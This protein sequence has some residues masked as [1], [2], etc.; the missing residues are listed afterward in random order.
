MLFRK[1]IE[2][3]CVYCRHGTKIGDN[4]IS[5]KPRGITQPSSYCRRFSYDP[6][7]RIPPKPVKLITRGLTD[8]DFKID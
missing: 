7:K 8:D 5:C 6:L 1:E 2:P 4:E 3:R